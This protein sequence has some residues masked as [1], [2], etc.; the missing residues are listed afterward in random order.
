MQELDDIMQSQGRQQFTYDVFKNAFDSDTRLQNLVS[1][2][3]K[4]SITFKSDNED[5]IKP[6]KPKKKI[7]TES[8][9]KQDQEIKILRATKY[10]DE[11]VSVKYSFKTGFGEEKSDVVVGSQ[12]YVEKKLKDKGFRGSIDYKKITPETIENK[13]KDVTDLETNNLTVGT[14]INDFH[15]R[16][17]YGYS[18]FNNEIVK[19]IAKSTTVQPEVSLFM[20]LPEDYKK[21]ARFIDRE[22]ARG[23]LLALVRKIAKTHWDS[24][25]GKNYYVAFSNHGSFYK[26]IFAGTDRSKA[27]NIWKTSIKNIKLGK[28]VG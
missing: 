5:Q 27:N 7:S 12:K 22:Y 1:D 8:S 24:K 21:N 25:R 16:E 17:E 10:S 18:F 26:V 13:K 3:D 11:K 15:S 20:G 2:F 6:K 19:S 4:K 9:W 14:S 23:N 28:D